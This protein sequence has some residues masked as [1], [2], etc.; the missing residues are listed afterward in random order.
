MDSLLHPESSSSRKIE[1][2][3]IECAVLYFGQFFPKWRNFTR[4]GIL[5]RC[6]R[7][8]RVETSISKCHFAKNVLW[9]INE[10]DG[11]SELT[12]DIF[13]HSN[14]SRVLH[15]LLI[16]V[17]CKT[18]RWRNGTSYQ[19]EKIKRFKIKLLPMFTKVDIRCILRLGF[20]L[21]T[22]VCT[23]IRAALFALSASV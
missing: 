19:A 23:C 14:M 13:H 8:N 5:F 21:R 3:K 7:C 1:K 18:F 17:C 12:A 6:A 9:S 11:N 20:Y 4:S 22:W 2:Q 10:L 16:L 15:A